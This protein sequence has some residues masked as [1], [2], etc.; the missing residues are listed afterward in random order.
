MMYMD[1]HQEL[2][3]LSAIE[4]AGRL[5]GCDLERNYEGKL[6][7]GRIVETEAYD[8][9]DIASHSFKGITP[10]NSVMFEAG[11]IAYV[12]FTYGMH[13][14]M[15]VVVG[16]KSIGA[17]VLIRAIEPLDGLEV[18]RSLRNTMKISNLCSGPAKLTQAMGINRL[19]N[20]HDLDLQPLRLILNDPIPEQ[21]I[22]WGKRIGIKEEPGSE[23]EWRA[24]L[25]G[26]KYLSRPL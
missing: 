3:A 26:S 10:R 2:S 16:R 4:A 11:G 7:K 14:C 23:L 15:N 13:Y 20:G 8:Q 22:V 6:L 9:S 12:Y 1:I 21:S 17:A 24:G 19:L 18:M 5:I 25:K